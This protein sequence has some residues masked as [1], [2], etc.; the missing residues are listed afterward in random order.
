MQLNHLNLAVAD[1]P[2]AQRFFETFFDFQCVDSKGAD[3]LAVLKGNGGFT[4]VLSNLDKAT[5]PVYPKDFHIGFILE[6]REQVEA[7]FQ[8]LQSAG[9]ELPH[10]PRT[11][12]GSYIF[13]CH[14]PSSILLE[15]SCPMK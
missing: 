6:S 10:Q 8:R 14:A 12:R 1:I 15:V 5:A 9:V 2:E 13:Y 11:M 7:L 3:T 4:L